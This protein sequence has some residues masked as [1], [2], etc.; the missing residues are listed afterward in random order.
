MIK[1]EKNIER[2]ASRKIFITIL[3]GV[4][5]GVVSASTARADRATST[6]FIIESG[7]LDVGG[8]VSTSTSFEVPGS[9]SQP[10]IDLS[11]STSFRLLGGFLA[12]PTVTTPVLSATAGAGAVTLTWTASE[13]F[14]GFNVTSY[15][16]GTGTTSDGE[17]FQDVGNVLTFVKTG[18]TGGQ[19]HF[20]KVRAKDEFGEVIAVSSEVSATPTAAGPT[21]GIIVGVPPGVRPPPTLPPE[22]ERLDCTGDGRIDMRDFSILLYFFNDRP[23]TALSRCYDFN[24]DNV[25]DLADAS[26]LLYYWTG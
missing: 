25:I 5:V 22:V 20:F 3:A 11:T 2:S 14:L 10:A 1:P 23:R 19:T 12:F 16:L 15:D 4:L 8:Q 13:G 21:P 26:I 18:L 7:V 9:L 24:G 6:N 17:T